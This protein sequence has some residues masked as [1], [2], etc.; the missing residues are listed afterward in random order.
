MCRRH[1]IRVSTRTRPN[2]AN[3]RSAHA[4]FGF[5]DPKAHQLVQRRDTERYH[6][7]GKQL[8]D[9]IVTPLPGR[10]P[11]ATAQ[12]SN[13]QCP[14]SCWRPSATS[15]PL[16][17]D[18]RPLLHLTETQGTL[19]TLYLPGR[20]FDTGRADGHAA[21]QPPFISLLPEEA[22]NAGSSTDLLPRT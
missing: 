3:A 22:E 21:L 13:P 9:I 10:S 18:A 1:P 5:S 11:Y 19:E 14:L 16:Q 2:A 4:Y 7:D 15:I 8:C 6:Q 12:R 20:R 17:N